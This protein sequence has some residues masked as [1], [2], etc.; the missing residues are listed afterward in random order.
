MAVIGGYAYRGGDSMA[1]LGGVERHILVADDDPSIQLVLK[2]MLRTLGAVDV[3]GDG[4]SAYEACKRLEYDLLV[5][6]GFM[7]RMDGY[8]LTDRLRREQFEFPIIMVT[9]SVPY[10][11]ADYQKDN[12]I[13]APDEILRK[14]IDAATLL[15]TAKARMDAYMRPIAVGE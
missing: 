13:Y 11:G 9:G 7:P 10:E 12:L 4:Q 15:K 8:R 14:P 2:R 6:D 5:T 1:T 3:V